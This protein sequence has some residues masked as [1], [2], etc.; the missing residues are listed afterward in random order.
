MSAI[1]IKGIPDPWKE[2]LKELASQHRRSVNQEVLTLLG[3]FLEEHA[4]PA[5]KKL[6]RFK[7]PLT[8]GYL[9]AAKREGRL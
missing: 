7:T 3:V 1:L 2:R 5:P 8:E 4:V 6:F 9:A